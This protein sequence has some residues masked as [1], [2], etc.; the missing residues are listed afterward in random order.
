MDVIAEADYIIDL[1]PEAGA[2]GGEIVAAG[3]PEQVAVARRSRTAPFLREILKRNP[4]PPPAKF[5]A[6]RPNAT[7]LPPASLELEL[8]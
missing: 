1:G 6:D 2:N 3:S 4:H 7:S 5:S 8:L